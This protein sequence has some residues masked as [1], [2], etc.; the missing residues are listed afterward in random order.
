MALKFIQFEG[1]PDDTLRLVGSDAAQ[2]LSSTV[3][4]V[5]GR[6][7]KGAIITVEDNP[8][9]IAFGGA[10]P[11]QGASSLG[12]LLNVGDVM[13]VYGEGMMQDFKYINANN[14]NNSVMQLTPLY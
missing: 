1:T 9:R 14:G 6:T 12:H 5:A 10:T 8:I 11:T 13:R 3:L 2:A 7:C 4:T